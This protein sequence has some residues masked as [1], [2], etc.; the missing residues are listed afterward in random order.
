M[1]ELAG[2]TDMTKKTYQAPALTIEATDIAATA[3]LS[4]SIP[5]GE[6]HTGGNDPIDDESYDI[7]G[8]YGNGGWGIGTPD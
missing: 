7:I 2:A 8:G 1:G 3:I 6:I 5:K 4:G